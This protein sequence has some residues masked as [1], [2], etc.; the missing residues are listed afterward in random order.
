MINPVKSLPVVLLE[1]Y[2]IGYCKTALQEVMLCVG[3]SGP[4]NWCEL[5]ANHFFKYYRFCGQNE[6]V[7]IAEDI[8]L[9]AI[10]K[11]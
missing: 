1:L 6:N 7:T 3:N 11:D 4:D 2:Q 8:A 10:L 5:I 9:F